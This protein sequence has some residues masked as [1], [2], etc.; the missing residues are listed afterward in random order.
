MTARVLRTIALAATLPLVSAVSAAAD[1]PT[2]ERIEALCKEEPPPAEFFPDMRL[3]AIKVAQVACLAG[4][5]RVRVA[6]AVIAFIET[7]ADAERLRPFGFDPGKNPLRAALSAIDLGKEEIPSIGRSGGATLGVAGGGLFAPSDIDS[8]DS[9]ADTAVDGKDCVSVIKEFAQIYTYAQ[10]AYAWHGA[11]AFSRS[12][13]D[14]ASQWDVFFENTRSQT[15]LEQLLNGYL[16]RKDERGHFSG[17]PSKQWILFHPNV[18][19][20]NVNDALDGEKSKEALMVEVVGLNWWSER[21]W[22]QPSG[23]SVIALYADR[24]GD[25]DVGYGLAIHFKGVYTVGY[26][27]HGDEGGVFVSGD[28]LKIFADKKALVDSYLR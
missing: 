22:Y 6:N 16:Y 12:A 28:L 14:F 19:I 2:R 18:V 27:I 9:L 17:P 1:Q 10:N 4:E 24:T 13:A 5:D 20:E 7:E 8:C 25:D 3:A 15:Y 21:P 11:L 23:V 26:S